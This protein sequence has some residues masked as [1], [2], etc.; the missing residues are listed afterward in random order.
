MTDNIVI[1]YKIHRDLLAKAIKENTFNVLIIAMPAFIAFGLAIG[2]YAMNHKLETKSN[3]L[4]LL[5]EQLTQERVQLHKEYMNTR[6][7]R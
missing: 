3:Q 6:K 1:D 5:K 4:N 7:T 2:M